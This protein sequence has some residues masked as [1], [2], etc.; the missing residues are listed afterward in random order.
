MVCRCAGSHSPSSG[1]PALLDKL[2]LLASGPE[3]VVAEP[4]NDMID[5]L[6]ADAL[7]AMALNP[8]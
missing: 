1:E 4:V 7:I 3:N 5:S 8:D 6:S 2:L